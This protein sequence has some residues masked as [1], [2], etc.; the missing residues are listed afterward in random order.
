MPQLAI[1]AILT[2][3]ALTTV[4]LPLAASAFGALVLFV[5]APLVISRPAADLIVK[6]LKNTVN[7]SFADWQDEYSR[8]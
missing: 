4:D 3:A 6:R 7:A 5:W 2:V 8:L 1:V